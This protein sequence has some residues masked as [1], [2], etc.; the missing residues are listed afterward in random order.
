MVQKSCI[1]PVLCVV[2]VCACVCAS[3]IV[4][5]ICNV[6]T[7]CAEGIFILL[8]YVRHR[9]MLNLPHTGLQAM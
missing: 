1:Y 9:L 8:A 3:R 6:S 2:Y 7:M 4:S 5:V